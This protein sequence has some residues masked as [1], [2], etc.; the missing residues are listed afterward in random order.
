MTLVF[1]FALF[2]AVLIFLNGCSDS[3]TEAARKAAT[4][5]AE[6]VAGFD[7]ENTIPAEQLRLS[8]VEC[9]RTS[10]ACAL[11]TT[12]LEVIAD[13]MASCTNATALCASVREFAGSGS[14]LL[15]VLP[16]GYP[17]VMPA[18]PFYWSLDNPLLE[19]RSSRFKYRMEVTQLWLNELHPAIYFFLVLV[20][21]AGWEV[22]V[23]REKDKNKR[24]IESMKAE[25]EARIRDQESK[26]VRLEEFNRQR[27][28][29][30]AQYE[31]RE[32]PVPDELLAEKQVDLE[33]TLDNAIVASEKT[34]I[35]A[36][37]NAAEHEAI[38][39]E[40]QTALS[41]GFHKKKSGH[42]RGSPD[43]LKATDKT[44]RQFVAPQ[45]AK[46]LIDLNDN[47]AIAEMAI[48]SEIEATVEVEAEAAL[49]AAFGKEPKR[50][51]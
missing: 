12:K 8:A 34:K 7:W 25:E 50:K 22:I 4:R 30:N 36:E 9:K 6:L 15:E 43:K 19:A 39:L 38:K 20:V 32:Y 11:L 46:R 35:E 3:P 21:I 51:M 18:H 31:L 42:R 24:N 45:Q 1:K 48:K 2:A 37:A 27:K 49:A 10:A 33:V 26:R 23:R 17:T 16:E 40:T 5:K 29:P 14:P 41:A 13:A 47:D 28:R 44:K